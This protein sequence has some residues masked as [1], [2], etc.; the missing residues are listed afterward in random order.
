MH[1]HRHDRFLQEAWDVHH[2]RQPGRQQQLRS[3]APGAADHDHHRHYGVHQHRPHARLPHSHLRQRAK[4]QS[5]RHRHR[6]GRRDDPKGKVTVKAGT[7]TLCKITL[8]NGTGS[9]TPKSTA[10]KAGSYSITANLAASSKFGGS[11]ST[12]SSLTINPATGSKASHRRHSKP[13]AK[14]RRAAAKG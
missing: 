12:A 9:C 3:S 6:C 8:L 7:A 13:H 10:L 5:H 14:S 1:P 4:R 11:T 2:R